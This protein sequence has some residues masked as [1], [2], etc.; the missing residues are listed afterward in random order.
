MGIEARGSPIPIACRL[1]SE[2]QL[3]RREELRARASSL[4]APRI[5]ASLTTATSS[6]SREERRE[7]RIW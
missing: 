3:H 5:L 4:P 1:T 2:E 7:P 6:S